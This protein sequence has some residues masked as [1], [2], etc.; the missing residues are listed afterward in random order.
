MA[1]HDLR[2]AS[3]AASAAADVAV[4]LDERAGLGGVPPLAE[5]E[6]QAAGL[7]RRQGDGHVQ[8]RA[9]VEAGAELPGER[10]VAQGRRLLERAVAADEGQA[11]AGRRAGG[12]LAWAKATRPANSW[13]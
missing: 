8:R 4:P 12:S 2:A 7:A 10:R 11:V 3:S 13:L 9:G 1:S 6:H 5:Q